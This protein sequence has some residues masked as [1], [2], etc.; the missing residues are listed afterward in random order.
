MPPSIIALAVVILAALVVPPPAW[1]QVEHR[2][3]VTGS[4]EFAHTTAD[5]GFLGSGAGWSAGLDVRLTPTTSVAVDAG[6][7]RHVREFRFGTAVTLPDGSLVP[8]FLRSRSDGTAMFLM[9]RLVHAFGRAAVRPVIWAGVG[10]MRAPGTRHRITNE[11]PLPPGTSLPPG[12]VADDR[13]PAVTAGVS[14][15]GGGLE[16]AW[17]AGWTVTP[18]AALRLAGTGNVGPKYILR[19]GLGAVWRW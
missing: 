11:S 15:G 14:E 8:H 2:L 7:E 4:L 10:V 5:D 17:R 12:F 1:S 6:A 18:Y 9:T 3:G 13:G 19:T 16:I